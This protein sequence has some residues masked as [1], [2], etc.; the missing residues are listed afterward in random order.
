[1]R[2]RARIVSFLIG[3]ISVFAYAP[4][5]QPVL[6]LFCLVGLIGLSVKQ[7]PRVG[8][9]LGFLFGLGCYIT[10][11]SWV[12]ISLSTYGGMPLWMGCIAVLGFA[13]VIAFFTGVTTCVSSFIAK[14]SE[15]LYLLVFPFAWVVLEWSKSWV[16]TGFPWLDLGYSQTT[17]W[18]GGWAP[19]GG[20]YLVSFVVASLASVLVVVYRE[21]NWVWLC[22]AVLVICLSWAV[23]SVS[24]TS[25]L[26]EPR[27]IGIVQANIPIEG[28]WSRDNQQRALAKYRDLSLTLTQQAKPELIIWPETALP[29][30]LSQTNNE[31]WEQMVP[32]GVDLLTG[33]LDHDEKHSYNAAVLSCAKNRQDPQIYR[34]RHLVPFG[35]YQPLTF[36]FGWVFEY[37]QLPMSD[38]IGWQGMQELQCDTGIN[39]GLSICYEDS[40]SNEYRDHLGNASVLVNISEDAWFGDSL[41]PHQRR[42]MAQM[43]AREL[44]RPMVR[45]AN[46]G[47]SLFIDEFGVLIRATAQFEDAIASE[48][49]QPM[50]GSTPFMN[51]GSW[52]VWLSLLLML[53][54]YSFRTAVSKNDANEN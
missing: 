38:F 52:I 27:Q 14:G 31:F 8:F 53:G 54:A 6:A 7:S 47:P 13:A 9:E 28:K 48:T 51:F 3:A 1:M 50:T 36:L 35:E 29:L 41:A 44:G 33:L 11:A 16:F 34:K 32:H 20:I 19:I 2:W 43:R 4:F 42:Q 24:W 26:G 21:R 46:S 15:R 49:V 22:P 17:T 23:S 37:L 12:Y 30:Y 39:I 18:L 5:E 10:G 40:F 45:S 25:P